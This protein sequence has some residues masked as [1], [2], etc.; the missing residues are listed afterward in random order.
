MRESGFDVLAIGNAIVDVLAQV[1]MDFPE[2]VGLGRGAMTLIDED[3][4]EQLYTMMP[5]G[6]E[7]SGGSAANTAAGLALLGASAAFVGKV[8][9]DQLGHVFIHDIRAVG[10][11]FSTR[12][13]PA[14]AATARSMILVTPDAQRTMATYL[15]ACV[16]LGPEDLDLD[17]VARARLVYLEGYLWD[18]PRAKRALRDAATVARKAGNR[19]ALSLSDAFCVDRHRAEFDALARDAVDILFAN[20]AEALSLTETAGIHDAIAA[21]KGR[22]PIVVI[23][24]G[25]LGSVVLAGD[26]TIEVPAITPRALMDTTGAGD[27]F[28]SGFLYGVSRGLDLADCAR[29]GAAAASE[30]IA[31]VGARPRGDLKAAVAAALPGAL[32]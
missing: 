23:T 27:L 21:L 8:R 3:Q 24:R 13:A 29:I 30:I 15:G 5:P 7:C 17:A 22:C 14:G 19:V 9:D 28:A 20:E 6:L 18:P 26:R 16:A 4:A 31:Q 12:P 10:V 32:D 25:A 11:H 2:R 1:E